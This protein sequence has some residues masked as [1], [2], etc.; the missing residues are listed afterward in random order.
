MKRI[1]FFITIL[2]FTLSTNAQ[3]RVYGSSYGLIPD[4]GVDATQAFKKLLEAVKD[5]EEAL[6]ILTAGRYD[7]YEEGAT[8]KEYFQSNTTDDNPKNL[9][10]LLEGLQNITIDGNFATFMFHGK[11]QPITIE[12]CRNIKIHRLYIDF[13]TPTSVEAEVVEVT[14]SYFE[15]KF[16]KKRY[17]Y[18]IKDKKVTFFVGK[19]ESHPF[20]FV[21][22]NDKL[23]IVEP[24]TGDR[25]W[26]NVEV[27][28]NSPGYLK[29]Y[30][31]IKDQFPKR[32]NWVVIRHGVRT[33]AGIFILNSTN[34]VI[35]N[36]NIY[37]TDGLG[38]LAQY[39]KNINFFSCSIVPNYLEER[40]YYSSHDD[41]LHIMG[42]SG[43]IRIE[44][45]E[46]FGLMDD[47][48]NVHGTYTQITKV[49][50]KKI[51]AKFM[52]PQSTGM[53]WGRYGETVAFVN[54]KDMSTM[55]IGVIKNYR[56]INKDEFEITFEERITGKVKVGM[57][58]ENL[59]CTPDVSIVNS[60][61][62]SGRARGLLISTPGNVWIEGN[63]FETSGSAILIAGDASN[64]F[65]SGPVKNVF[66]KNNIFRYSCMSS[67]Y[68][69]SEAVITI[70]PEIPELDPQKP[71]HS[72]IRIEDN[73]FFLFDYPILYAKSVDGLTF[74]K[75]RLYRS[76]EITPF[77]Y[78]KFGV[79]LIGCKNVFVGNNKEEGEILGKAVIIEN[80]D[81]KEVNKETK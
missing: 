2:L 71:Y 66:V 81:P 80:M 57:V 19:H 8:Q 59:T 20:G 63:I 50:S 68:Q 49:S 70:F 45:C 32:N 39:S 15:V 30:T 13:A 62:R 37:Q 40:K 22:F 74:I 65:E 77:H 6:I 7:F 21:E 12:N 24:N 43:K 31:H 26:Q 51:R 18:E 17:P 48:I 78:N 67:L 16:D 41:G 76:K 11:L 79:K 44:N 75:N 60:R 42:C 10:I 47:A 29:I 27:V 1:L 72:N 73:S 23:K 34:V 9:S 33:H 61:I 3:N 25:S 64:W 38:I 46:F 58:I 36:V 54:N 69:Y 56:K 14:D 5:E 4:T 53:T 52:H 55:G 35:Q 28:E